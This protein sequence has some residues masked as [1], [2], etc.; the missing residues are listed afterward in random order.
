M[1]WLREEPLLTPIRKDL[2]YKVLYQKGG[3]SQIG[4]PIKPAQAHPIS[5]LST[6]VEE[7]AS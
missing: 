1:T 4:L 6:L 7:S 2:R 5:L 3:F